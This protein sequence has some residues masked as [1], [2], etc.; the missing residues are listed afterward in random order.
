VY[1][2][3]GTIDTNG[4]AITIAQPLLAPTGSGINSIPVATGGAGYIDT[5]LVTLS[6]GSGSGATAVAIVSGGSVTGF[7]ITNPGVGYLPGDTISATLL[8][9]GAT[10]PAT[11]GMITVAPN[12]G[13]GLTKT[14]TGTLTLSGSQQLFGA[15]SGE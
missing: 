5:P 9:G 1:G 2:E 13:G 3:G 10:T 12:I 4:N 15:D 8:G 7:T 14:G 11:V 6:G